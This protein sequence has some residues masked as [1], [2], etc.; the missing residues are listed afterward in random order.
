LPEKLHGEL[1]R[2]ERWV[3]EQQSG[4]I[5][6]PGTRR[7]FVKY[8]QLVIGIYCIPVFV[9]NLLVFFFVIFFSSQI[10]I[11][12]IVNKSY[13]LTFGFIFILSFLPIMNVMVFVK[14]PICGH[15]ILCNPDH[16]H[17]EA[18]GNYWAS[19]WK[20]IKKKPF[21]C[22]DCADRYQFHYTAQHIEIIKLN[23]T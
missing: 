10:N 14:N 18:K 4:P 12:N 17:P 19:A 21:T 23:R 13:F 15:A 5:N 16:R 11:G 9:L 2:N 6:Q 22:L 1:W 20:I 7:P 3:K 8:K